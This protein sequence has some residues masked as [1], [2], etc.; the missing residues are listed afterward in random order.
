MMV[1]EFH[2]L[3][4][5]FS[6]TS[7]WGAKDMRPRVSLVLLKIACLK[8]RWVITLN[9]VVISLVSCV[10][11][12]ASKLASIVVSLGEMELRGSP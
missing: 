6:K 9:A 12:V 1:N 7:S 5:C 3:I 2:S 4:E 8:Y 10:S 11:V